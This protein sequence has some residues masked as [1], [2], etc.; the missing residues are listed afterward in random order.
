MA[1]R[2]LQRYGSIN[3][4][5]NLV[6][7]E[8]RTAL[9]KTENVLIG[10]RLVLFAHDVMNIDEIIN[11][12]KYIH[13]TNFKVDFVGLVF[14][15]KY[16]REVTIKWNEDEATQIMECLLSLNP[17]IGIGYENDKVETCKMPK[18]FFDIRCKTAKKCGK[19]NAE[20]T[21]TA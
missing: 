2:V 12:H 21:A 13:K 20:Y 4:I 17:D 6:E 7:D 14:K 16:E 15:D 9:F 11:V 18:S 3:D 10:K 19:M 5:A 1:M 8:T